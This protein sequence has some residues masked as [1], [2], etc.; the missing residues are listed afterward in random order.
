[1]SKKASILASQ[2]I[3]DRKFWSTFD[4]SRTPNQY[5]GIYLCQCVMLRLS[6]FAYPS[7][8][9]HSL[10]TCITIVFVNRLKM[11]EGMDQR[12][13]IQSSSSIVSN[14]CGMLSTILENVDSSSSKVLSNVLSISLEISKVLH[15]IVVIFPCGTL[16]RSRTLK[17][18]NIRN[19]LKF[20]IKL[21]SCSVVEL[22]PDQEH[23]NTVTSEIVN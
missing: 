6:K 4:W 12:Q 16:S 2:D 9:V 19:H 3:N 1:V 17:H 15:Q 20:S 11:W 18:G 10:T 8:I 14:P 5:L 7:Y 23:W 22:C 21:L 13:N